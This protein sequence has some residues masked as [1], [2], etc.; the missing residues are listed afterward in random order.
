MT[1]IFF[2]YLQGNGRWRSRYNL[3][4]FKGLL[5]PPHKLCRK[6][7]SGGV[8]LYLL[9]VR[10]RFLR[11]FPYS[12]TR[13]RP[14]IWRQ[15][16]NYDIAEEEFTARELEIIRNVLR[17]VKRYLG[18]RRGRGPLLQFRRVDGDEYE[19][20]FVFIQK[21]RL[22]CMSELGLKNRGQQYMYMSRGCGFS[23]ASVAHSLTC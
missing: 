9:L 11:S 3:M 10:K 12:A 20:N 17:D 14:R 1:F 4:D 15:F 8:K 13:T 23:Y 22:Y 5:V 6:A 21:H 16:F 2:T 19:G 7:F 18:S